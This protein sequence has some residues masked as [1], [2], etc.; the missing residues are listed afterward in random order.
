MIHLHCTSG[1]SDYITDMESFDSFY[2]YIENL[3]GVSLLLEMSI[4]LLFGFFVAGILKLFISS[5]YI[6][7]HLSNGGFWDT[8]KAS[9]FGVPLPICSCGVIPVS[10]H[11]KK[12]GASNSS[13]ISFLV[14]TPTSG[15]DSILATYSLLGPIF[16]IFRPVAS[17]VGGVLSGN[18]VSIFTKNDKSE[19]PPE[20]PH[21]CEA[22]IAEHKSFR[23]KTI[24]ALKYAFFELVESTGKWI[25]IGLLL[26]A[27]ISFAVPQN[28]IADYLSN[29]FVSYIAMLLI[30]IPMYV[31]ATG[32][33]PIAASLVMKGMSPGAALIFLIAG[34]ATNTATIA[35][36]A[37]RMGKKTVIIYLITIIIVSVFFAFLFD[38]IASHYGFDFSRAH[39]H[40]AIFPN[41]LK[42]ISAIAL[43]ALIIRPYLKRRDKMDGEKFYI[44]DITCSHC[45][46][47]IE[48][49]V[50]KVEGVKDALVDVK[51]KELTVKGKYKR[52]DILGAIRKAGYTA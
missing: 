33:I 2:H 13:V 26:G 48:E 30:G 20:S 47:T 27:V 46:K 9:A 29:K 10:E 40:S 3:P 25:M 4:Y 31:C 1:K 19:K 6:A 45:A 15:V 41:Y 16:A 21:M 18:L 24:M 14:S 8:V 51:K 22:D 28:F 52:E 49:A 38:M 17:F 44:S 43:L 12:S 36:I 39:S 32:S 34:P 11:L 37:G 7:K 35:F 5:E 42:L 50:K 23:E